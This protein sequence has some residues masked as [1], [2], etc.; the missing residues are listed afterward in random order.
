MRADFW[1]NGDVVSLCNGLMS[2]CIAT[3]HAYNEWLLINKRTMQTSHA[4]LRV[5]NGAMGGNN[6]TM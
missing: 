2:A 4:A 6:V 5:N 1:Q 3:M